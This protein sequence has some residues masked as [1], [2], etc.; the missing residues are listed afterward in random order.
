MKMMTPQ[1]NVPNHSSKNRGQPALPP[2]LQALMSLII[3]EP[4]DK[5]PK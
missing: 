2:D 1:L 4:E 3:A 5:P